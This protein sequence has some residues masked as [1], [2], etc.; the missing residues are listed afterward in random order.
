MEN[1]PYGYTAAEA[2][3]TLLIV[4]IVVTLSLAN[5]RTA[6]NAALLRQTVVNVENALRDAQQ[7]ALAGTVTGAGQTY[8]YGVHFETSSHGYILFADKDINNSFYESGSDSL[9]PAQ[10]EDRSSRVDLK[11][12]VV[13]IAPCTS[14]SD[15]STA[16]IVYSPP[17][18]ITSIKRMVSENC[19]YDIACLDLQLASGSKVIRVKVTKSS[20][21]IETIN[22]ATGACS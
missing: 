6:Q 10:P 8:G 7:H 21:L 12:R 15:V 11:I 14:D 5:Y 4:A 19:S 17:I 16:D 2:L 3:V 20:G 18:P 1:R 9:V 22:N 13:G